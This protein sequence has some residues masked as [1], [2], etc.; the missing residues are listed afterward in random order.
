MKRAFRIKP[1]VPSLDPDL[2]IPDDLRKKFSKMLFTSPT[3]LEIGTVED[4]L[5]MEDCPA[6]MLKPVRTV[7]VTLHASGAGTLMPI[8][9]E[10]LAAV[11]ADL[12]YTVSAFSVE[13]D[14]AQPVDANGR[15]RALLTLYE[16]ELPKKI[17]DQYIIHDGRAYSPDWRL[18]E[19]LER[20][21]VM[22]QVKIKGLGA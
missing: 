20:I 8:I 4:G 3:D 5:K 18:M 15:Q 12:L 13:K 1:L 11:P 9:S 7:P 19:K 14:K 6:D 22:K 21:P 10:L 2:A 16:G 17:K